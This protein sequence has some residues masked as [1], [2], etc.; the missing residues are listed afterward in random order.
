M[1][2]NHPPAQ[3]TD[4]SGV[5]TIVVDTGQAGQ[6][7]DNFL[8]GRLKGVPRSHIYRLLRSGQ[9]RVNKGRKKPD[10]RLKTG[11]SVRIPP[12]R[13]ATRLP[14]SVPEALLQTLRDS[15]LLEDE[16]LLVLNKPSGLAV[17]GGSELRF[18]LIDAMHILYPDQFLELAHRLDRDTSGALVLA[19]NRAT[20]NRLHDALRREGQ[21]EIETT[22]LALVLGDWP[23]GVTTIDSPL[24]KT[25]RG[26][27]HM[28]EVNDGGQHAI[29]HFSKLRRYRDASLVQVRIETGR[30]H[31]IRV[32]AASSGHPLAGDPKYGDTDFNRRMKHYGLR[33]LFLHASRIVLPLDK[34]IRIDAPLDAALQQILD[35]LGVG[36]LNFHRREYSRNA[37]SND[38]RPRMVSRSIFSAVAGL[39]YA[40]F[41]NCRISSLPVMIARWLPP[42]I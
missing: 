30:T 12:L 19:K 9:V 11:D 27:E 37:K 22:Y 4:N 10:Y 33:R 7:I 32:H 42:L 20:L 21:H 36:R 38:S 34:K 16:N 8:L 2:A 17:H 29:S 23:E 24:L 28:V 31:Q 6:R 35:T 39:A 25:L 26:G 18:G 41:P 14:V 5:N 15:I 1:P 40:L 13:T 3:T